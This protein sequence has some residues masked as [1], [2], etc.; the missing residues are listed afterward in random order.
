MPITAAPN[1]A[2]PAAAARNFL[3]A[4]PQTLLLLRR[5]FRIAP[6]PPRGNAASI[7]H[8][9]MRRWCEPG[10]NQTC[11]SCVRAHKRC[12]TRF[13]HVSLQAEGFAPL[14]CR[15]GVAQGM[16]VSPLG[17]SDGGAP[18]PPLGPRRRPA[19]LLAAVAGLAAL[20]VIALVAA[21]LIPAGGGHGAGRFSVPRSPVTSTAPTTCRGTRARY[22]GRTSRPSSTGPRSPTWRIRASTRTGR[23]RPTSHRFRRPRS[24]GRSPPT[25]PTRSA[26]RP[27]SRPTCQRSAE[28]SR[29]A[30]GPRPSARGPWRGATTCI[31]APST[32]CCPARSTRRLTGCRT[33][34]RATGR[35]R[36]SRGCTGSST[37]CGPARS[38]QSLVRWA[39]QLQR[40]AVTLRQVLPS[41]QITPLDYAT[42]AHEILED[43]QRDLLSGMDVQWSGAGVLGTAAGLAATEEVIGTLTPL[44]QARD[45]TLAE[46]Q[47][48]LPQLQNVLDGLRKA[49]SRNLSVARAVDDDPARAARRHDGRDARRTLACPRNARDDR[50]AGDS[51]DSER[52]IEP[53]RSTPL[54]HAEPRSDR[55]RG[56]RSGRRRRVR[57]ADGD[58]RGRAWKRRRRGGAGK[59]ASARAQAPVRWGPPVGDPHAQANEATFVAL[60]SI[61]PNK[62]VLFQALEALSME[63]RLLTQGD[64][65]GVQE[66][67]DPPPDSGI[68]GPVDSPDSLTVTIALRRVAVRR[69]IRAGCGAPAPA[70]RDARVRQRPARPDADRRRRPAADLRGSARHGRAHVPRADARDRSAARGALDDR[71]LPVGAAGTVRQEQPAQP[72]RVPRRDLEPRRHRPAP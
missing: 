58:E 69:A 35:G 25:G 54:H 43:A 3:L 13:G 39:R 14:A 11:T 42:R 63:A 26:G 71:R 41:V 50:A 2:A 4:F 32:A 5:R 47:S 20:A 66:V 64:T 59:C 62:E 31:S 51:E 60:D 21:A 30:G 19:R 53:G 9:T 40:D 34:S 37:G 49:E 38:P 28:R 22:S 15:A 8:P 45:N 65:V 68:L 70:D 7:L 67:D 52:E 36:I 16:A 48:W 18:N 55:R 44:L 61:A 72:V 57:V 56:R 46:V 29:A 24:T 1:A 27:R 33:C 12:R 6:R 23:W 10:V 17:I